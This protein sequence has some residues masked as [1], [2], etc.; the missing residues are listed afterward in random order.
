MSNVAAVVLLAV[1]V[2]FAVRVKPAPVSPLSVPPVTTTSL[3][4]K[5]VPGSSLNVKVIGAVPSALA[6]VAVVLIATVGRMVSTAT[7][8]VLSPSEPSTLLTLR[9]FWNVPL[10]TF[11]LTLPLVSAGGVYVAV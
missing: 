3:R 1:G 9:L 5:L 4:V 6:M 10:A 11:R 8:T 7:V 2:K